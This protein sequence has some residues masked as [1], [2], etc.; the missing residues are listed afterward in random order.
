L[1]L[2][3]AC[4]QRGVTMSPFFTLRT[5]QDQGAL[6]RQGKTPADAELKA[7]ALDNVKARFLAQCIR[8][9]PPKE[10]NNV[11]DAI[12]GYSWHQWGEAV[13]CCWVD[14]N[15]KVNWS[16]V[17]VVDGVNGYQIYAQEAEKLGLT[18]GG[19]WDTKADWP[20]VQL[21]PE[22]DPSHLGIETINQEMQKRFS[23]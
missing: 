8:N 9:N 4:N 21:R 20:H 13:D 5:P 7:L 2:I 17:R 10:T 18:A 15:R 14:V 12:P 3:E 6:W 1:E 23:K 16:Y 19:R 22:R 11:T